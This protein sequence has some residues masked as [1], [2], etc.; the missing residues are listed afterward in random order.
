MPR[1]KT[2]KDYPLS[3]RLPQSDL[4]AIDRA[5]RMRGS[6]R[7]NFIR[8]AAVRAAEEAI[9]ENTIIRM[10]P[11]G[12]VAFMAELDRSPVV[13]PEIVEIFKRRAPWESDGSKS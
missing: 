4:A 1:P 11:K 5:A 10:S 8:D 7:S 2:R 3:M 13:V 9:L 6:S 12:F